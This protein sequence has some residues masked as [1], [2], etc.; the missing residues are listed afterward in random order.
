[1]AKTGQFSDVLTDLC[2]KVPEKFNIENKIRL[3]AKSK[4]E[5][6]GSFSLHADDFSMMLYDIQFWLYS[7]PSESVN[8]DQYLTTD[9]TKIITFGT[10]TGSYEGNNF[11]C[12]GYAPNFVSDD[13]LETRIK[14][15]RII[16]NDSKI[17]ISPSWIKELE[18][19]ILLISI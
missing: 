12:G 19:S 6:F 11:T 17:K 9:Y 15:G 2:T 18:E 4:V 14:E 3:L 5:E 13:W 10:F 1:M 8:K 16:E 7:Y